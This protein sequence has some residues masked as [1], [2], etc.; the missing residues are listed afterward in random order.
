M[1]R[2]IA[3]APKKGRFILAEGERT[4]HHHT[5]KA[6]PHV[7]FMSDGPAA[8]LSVQD[9]PAKLTHQEHDTLTIAPGDY[10]VVTQ[11]HAMP[12]D[13]QQRVQRVWD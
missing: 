3:V 7:T 9:R 6:S 4:G 12:G 5:V 13:E 2:A 10:E 1:R 8:F 11:R